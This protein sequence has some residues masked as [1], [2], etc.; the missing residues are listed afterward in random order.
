MCVTPKTNSVSYS[1]KN[2]EIADLADNCDYVE[3]SSDH[4]LLSNRNN[5]FRIVQFN[6]RGVR[7]KYHELL[8][9]CDKL[10]DPEV[11]VL[12]ETWLKPSDP[13]PNI[14][15][16]S[17]S[18]CDRKNRKGGGIGILVKNNLKSRLFLEYETDSMECHV[19]ELKGNRH[20]IIIAGIYRPPNTPV[21]QFVD[22]YSKLSD[23]LQNEP[24]VLL[25][26]DHN[27]DFLKHQTHSE[28][29]RFLEINLSANLIPSIM[30]PTHVTTSSATLIDNIFVRTSLPEALKSGIVVDNTSDHF[31]LIT[32]IANPCVTHC[33]PESY[34]TR[35]LG[36]T[37][38]NKIS[39]SLDGINWKDRLL[40][41]TA[42]EAFN[43]FH[44]TLLH[45]MNIVSPEIVKVRKIKRNTPW[46]TDSIKKCI[47]KDKKLYKKSIDNPCIENTLKYQDYHKT[48]LKVK[49]S[50]KRHYYKNLCLEYKNDSKSYGP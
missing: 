20:N 14:P 9:I 43:D 26:M 6:I 35:K 50:T 23:R 11:I 28:M 7:S 16:Y 1:N 29:Q 15:G 39:S 36:V 38:I 18:G 4:E 49:C 8:D 19:I 17:F 46:L 5:Q 40:N 37:E 34:T 44:D 30:K 10:N 47:N 33:E 48:L 21:K 13:R 2:L 3:W 24:V 41:K 45:T 27:L 31:I 22:D 32:E 42:D 12:C 25:A